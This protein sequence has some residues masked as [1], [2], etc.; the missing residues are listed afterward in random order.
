MGW[1]AVPPL[2]AR[3]SP[4]ISPSSLHHADLLRDVPREAAPHALVALGKR[5][6]DHKHNRPGGYQAEPARVVGKHGDAEHLA[7]LGCKL[8]Q[9]LEGEGRQREEG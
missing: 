7:A 4:F 1:D 6:R 3:L 2:T 5:P 8:N 9:D